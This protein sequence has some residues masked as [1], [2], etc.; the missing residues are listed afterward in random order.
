MSQDREQRIFNAIDSL[1]AHVVPASPDEDEEEAQERHYGCFDLAKSILEKYAQ[2][3]LHPPLS[4]DTVRLTAIAAPA[5]DPP[6]SHQ[7]STT[8]PTS[9][10]AS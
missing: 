2:G 4:V 8:P 6:P 9:S 1:I 3:G 10:S 7:T 5:L